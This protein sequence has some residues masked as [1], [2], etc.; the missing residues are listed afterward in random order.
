MGAHTTFIMMKVAVVLLVVCFYHC[1]GFL[2]PKV[3]TVDH[4]DIDKYMG[5]FY[6]IYSTLIQRQT[7]Q[8]NSVCTSATYTLRK[9]GIVKVYNSGRK[10]TPTGEFSAINGTAV[11]TKD[12]GAFIVNFPKSP[13]ATSANY[14]VVKLGPV[15]NGLYDY[16][17]VST[18]K[19]LMMWVLARD[20]ATFKTKY[21]AEVKQFLKDNGYTWFWNKARE[22]YQGADCLY[23]PM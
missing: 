5:R 20:P 7:F 23:P 8:K 13:K 19:K 22:T 2:F 18:P 3:K 4:L 12:P 17:V 15:V 11:P 10:N 21:D 16:S 6:E 1:H 14:L 9:D